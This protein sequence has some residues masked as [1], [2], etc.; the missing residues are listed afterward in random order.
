[1]GADQAGPAGGF[2]GLLRGHR[3]A[4][5]LSQEELGERSGLTARAIANMERGRTARP[6]RRS[7]RALADALALAGPERVLLERA[8]RSVVPARATAPSPAAHAGTPGQGQGVPRQPPV[9]AAPFMRFSLPADT[10]AFTGRAG[11]IERIVGA[12]TMPAPAH[13]VVRLCAVRGMPG[14]GKTAL[15]VHAAHLLA[16]QFGDRQ[17]YVDLHGRTAGRSPLPA[18]D[19]LAGLLAS[20]GVEAGQMPADLDGRSALWRD[21]LAGQRL[22]IVLDNAAESDQ[23]APLLPGTCDCLVLVT[24]R[25]HLA[26]LP[27]TTESILLAPLSPGEAAEMFTRLA[28]LAAGDSPAAVNELAEVAGGLPL[29]VSL[30]ARARARHP[31]WDLQDLIGEARARMLSLAA[32]HATVEAAFE[33]SWQRL[34]LQAQAFLALAGLHPAANLDPLAAAALTGQPQAD[35]LRLLEQLE[36]EGLLA[37]TGYRRYSLH[38]LIRQYVA[39]R[40]GEAVPGPE[41]Q[42]ALGRLLDYYERAAGLADSLLPRP[43]RWN[44]QRAAIAA[45]AAIPDLASGDQALAW[46]RAEREALL[47]C[48]DHLAATGQRA[49]LVALT[50]GLT[51]LLRRDGPWD[52][53]RALHAAAAQAAE[54]LGHRAGQAGALLSLGDVERLMGDSA[55]AARTLTAALGIFRELGD[56]LGL[57]AALS[58]LGEAQRVTGDNLAAAASLEEALDTYRDQGDQLGTAYATYYLATVRCL[59]DRLPEAGRLLEGA[60]LLFSQLGDQT[61]KTNA[62][63]LLALGQKEL[64]DY[65]AAERNLTE[66][67]GLA[68]ELGNRLGQANALAF[69]GAVRQTTGHYADAA[70]DLATAVGLYREIGSKHG[71]ANALFYQGSLM[72]RTGDYRGARAVLASA[73]ELAERIG[74]SIDQ[75]NALAWLAEAAW[76]LN[77]HA[78]AEISL[79]RS[80]ALFREIGDRTGQA[81]VLNKSGTLHLV[82]GDLAAAR[83]DYQQALRVAREI[84]MPLEESRALAGL[85]RCELASADTDSAV[86]LL[87]QALEIVDRTGAADAPA[88]AAEL[89]DIATRPGADRAGSVAAEEGL[90]LR[91]GDLGAVTGVDHQAGDRDVP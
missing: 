38:D 50:A 18:E 15:A 39:A 7:V 35:A 63:N 48:R 25:R 16:P 89:A 33:V 2:G 4:A 29:A 20:A 19:V 26:D 67:L 44:P 90:D 69:R 75:A 59:T 6:Y 64:G 14:V 87:R 79:R 56:R 12:A 22:L 24:S 47:A 32:E 1:V 23:V 86:I 17:L 78:E 80:L 54:E 43:H 70:A 71:E 55:A 46:L 73:L 9:P 62:V 21:Q 31:A 65:P 40:A 42:S 83:D 58:A 28:P 41:R 13:G 10:A 34:D 30:L 3:Q 5:G 77:G 37:E 68:R 84:R 82:Q 61:G 60:V 66:A 53:A 49:R 57:A 76:N 36:A 74:S 88:I 11:E 85:G 8:S 27:G 91:T 81:E 45:E 72:C 52:Q 51:G